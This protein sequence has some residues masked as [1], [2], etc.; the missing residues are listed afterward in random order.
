MLSFLRNLLREHPAQFANNYESI[1][2][3]L[4]GGAGGSHWDFTFEQDNNVDVSEIIMRM[5]YVDRNGNRVPSLDKPYRVIVAEQKEIVEQLRRFIADNDIHS[6]NQFGLL[7]HFNWNKDY[8]PK[9]ANRG[10]N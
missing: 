6:D 9:Y 5:R 7:L 3:F 2:G 4:S 1:I 8:N 10:D